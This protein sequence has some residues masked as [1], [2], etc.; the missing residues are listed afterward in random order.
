MMTK[1]KSNIIPHIHRFIT[2]ELGENYWFNGCGRYVMG[3]LGE[4]DYDYEFFAGVTGDVFAQ[5]YTYDRFRGDGVTDYLLSDGD[6]SFIG[7]IFEK[8]GYDSLFVA[9]K[10]L[11]SHRET[12]LRKLL[13]YIDRGIPVISNLI[14]LGHSAWIVFVGYEDDGKTL[15]FMTDN[16]T[17]PERVCAQDVFCETCGGETDE[18]CGFLFVGE[19]KEQKDLGQIYRNAIINLPCLLTTRTKNYCFGASAFRAWADE[20]ESGRYDAMKP[21]EFDSWFMYCNYVC[22]PATNASCCHEFLNRARRFNPDFAFIGQVDQIYAKMQRMWQTDP[23]G[24]EA[25]GGGFNITLE[26]LQDRRR[27]DRIVA[28]IREFADCAE[29]V[30]RILKENLPSENPKP[31]V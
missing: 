1:H 29:E 28:K 26:A 13:T 25:I 31:S 27:R 21:E 30:V 22:V 14:I 7:E 6:P 15:L 4:P 3:A 17:G 24:L 10:E 12:Y 20:I 5:I 16:M 8:C 11:K 18:S 9:E 2:N 23:D 19:K